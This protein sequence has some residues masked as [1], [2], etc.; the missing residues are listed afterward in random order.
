MKSD[1]VLERIRLLADWYKAHKPEV[2]RIIVTPADYQV[3]E[4]RVGSSGVAMSAIGIVYQGFLIVAR[5]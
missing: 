2:T 3:I 1:D 4:R 5:A